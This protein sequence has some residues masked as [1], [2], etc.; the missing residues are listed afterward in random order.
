MTDTNPSLSL[1]EARAIARRAIE[2][3]EDLGRSGAFVVVD[4]GG[5]VIT[6]SRMDG[7]GSLSYPVSRAKAYGAAVQRE[8]SAAFAERFAHAS[9]GIFSAFQQLTR[10]P[11]F[12]GPGAQLVL[13][14][15]RLVGAISTGLGVPPFVKFPGLDPMKLIVEG[16]PAN[17][18]DLCIS[19]ALRKPYAP[20]HGDDMKRWMEAYGKAPEGQGTGFAEAPGSTKQ[21]ELDAAIRMCDA[22]MAEA[23]RRKSLV[24]VVVVDRHANMIQIDRMDGAA[25]MTPDAAEALAATAVN[26]HAPSGEAAKYPNLSALATVTGFKYLPVPGGL[27]LLQ[28]GRAIGAIGISGADPEECEAIARAAIDG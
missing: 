9:A 13:K 15:G 10:E 12:P 8:P 3:A 26:F 19:Y 23:K 20:Q 24:S 22:A 18:E 2:K 6:A 25:P 1:E 16:K 14:A 27:P 5:V 28:N 4:D 21:L 7:T 11:V 17:A